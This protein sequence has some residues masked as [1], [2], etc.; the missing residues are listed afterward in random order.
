MRAYTQSR[1]EVCGRGAAGS[2]ISGSLVVKW[3]VISLSLGDFS[4]QHLQMSFMCCDVHRFEWNLVFF[5][6]YE[7]FSGRH[8]D[9]RISITHPYVTCAC[10]LLV[11]LSST[12]PVPGKQYALSVWIPDISYKPAR[13]IHGRLLSLSPVL[14]CPCCCAGQYLITFYGWVIV[15]NTGIWAVFTFC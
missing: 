7:G 10:L 6:E 11:P 12:P 8:G 14:A 15:H 2:S 3:I 5:S 4:H 9:C 13:R 1:T